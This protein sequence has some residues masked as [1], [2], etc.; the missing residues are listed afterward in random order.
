MFSQNIGECFVGKFL[1]VLHRVPCKK[2]KPVPRSASNAI[3]LRLKGA[4]MAACPAARA[5]SRL[6]ECVCFPPLVFG[7]ETTDI[8]ELP[9]LFS[10]IACVM[11]RLSVLCGSAR[12]GRV[13]S[14]S[15]LRQR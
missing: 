2:L 7:K 12:S 8:I 11:L 1:N 6:R 15:N 4:S 5:S 10:H 3:S 13:F 14:R 9:K